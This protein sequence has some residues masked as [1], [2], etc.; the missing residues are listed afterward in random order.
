MLKTM[1]ARCCLLLAAAMA[2]GGPSLDGDGDP[3]TDQGTPPDG[4]HD[5]GVEPAPTD[6][7]TVD[8]FD[9]GGDLEPDQGTTEPSVTLGTGETAFE[10]LP[11]DG[12]LEL[13]RGSQGGVH[14]YV[15]ARI[16][17]AEP[18]AWIL[19]YFGY[20]ADD[21]LRIFRPTSRFLDSTDVIDEGDAVVRAGDRLILDETRV[22]QI[23]I[24]G[25]Q[26]RIEVQ[27]ETPEGLL[28][29]S[30]LVTVVDEL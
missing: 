28:T 5:G 6:A 13:T 30:A 3:S 12:N 7:A 24:V 14:L 16:V 9:D 23:A 18:N 21:G 2:C 17:G 11:S 19:R 27:L 4:G 20:R 15:G 22:D 25:M 26:V 10:A 1:T 8:A 29:D